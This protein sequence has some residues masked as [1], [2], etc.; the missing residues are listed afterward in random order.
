[1]PQRIFIIDE[2]GFLWEKMPNARISVGRRK[3]KPS[4]CVFK[5]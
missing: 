2:I 4:V 1:M 5:E 3:V